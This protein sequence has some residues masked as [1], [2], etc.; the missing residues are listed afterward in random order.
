MID[1]SIVKLIIMGLYAFVKRY[2]VG[3]QGIPIL[4]RNLQNPF[5]LAGVWLSPGVAV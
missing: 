3:H 1:M 5:F 4:A 2:T